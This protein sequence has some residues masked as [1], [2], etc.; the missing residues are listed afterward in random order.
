MGSNI[1]EAMGFM[2]LQC[3]VKKVPE[4]HTSDGPSLILFQDVF[5]LENHQNYFISLL[6]CNF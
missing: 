4:N 5:G 6:I 2:T 1:L 3:S